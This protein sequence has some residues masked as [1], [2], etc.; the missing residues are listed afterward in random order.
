MGIARELKVSGSPL[1]PQFLLAHQN[2][3]NTSTKALEQTLSQLP[4]PLDLWLV[5]FHA[6]AQVNDC[7]AVPLSSP[8]V[9]GYQ[10]R[11]YHC[12]T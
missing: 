5:N 8:S 11:L 12:P 4:R 2:Q 10:Y 6:P 7:V 9:N 3:P 1:T